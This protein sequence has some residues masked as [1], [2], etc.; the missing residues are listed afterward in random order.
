LLENGST[1]YIPA[2]HFHRV[3]K[4]NGRLL[5]EVEKSP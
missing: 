3:I 5:I 4:G 2:Y 1:Y